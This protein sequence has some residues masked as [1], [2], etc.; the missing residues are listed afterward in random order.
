MKQPPA[1]E[2]APVRLP[3]SN[4]QLPSASDSVTAQG[5]ESL[6]QPTAQLSLPSVTTPAIADTASQ[7][8]PLWSGP[9]PSS[10]H[11]LPPPK[12]LA[13]PTFK[14][15]EHDASSYS[16]S[17]SSANQEVV[18]WR[19]NLFRAPQ[20]KG[21]KLFVSELARLYRAYAEELSPYYLSSLSKSL[22]TKQ[23]PKN[24]MLV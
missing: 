16:T 8:T 7:A 17:L 6:S 13:S 2:S 11:L 23:S 15:G 1:P 22:L 10:T 14:W 9:T 20:G 3:T 5:R 19:R 18:H 21:G 24:L 12:L 4:K